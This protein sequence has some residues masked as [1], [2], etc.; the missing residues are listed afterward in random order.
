MIVH[1]LTPILN[2]SDFNENI[3]LLKDSVGKKAG[4]G[5]IRLSSAVFARADARF[6]SAR[7]R[8][9]DGARATTK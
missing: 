4:I 5:A 7:A 1:G 9:A 2:V 3:A 6:F 8:K